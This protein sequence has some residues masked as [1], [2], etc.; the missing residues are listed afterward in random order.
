MNNLILTRFKRSARLLTLLCLLTSLNAFGNAIPIFDFESVVKGTT[1]F[2]LSSQ[3][4]TLTG[5]MTNEVS[6]ALGAPAAGTASPDSNGYMD[7]GYGTSG[8]S[9]GLGNVG[10]IKAPAGYTF[11]ATSF[12]V[13][14]S[15]DGGNNVYGGTDGTLGT[16]GLKYTVIGMKNNVMVVSNNVTDTARTPP[17]TGAPAVTLGGY[18]HH[19]AYYIDIYTLQGRLEV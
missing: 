11:R 10:G 17:E 13:W 2:S 7:T 1:S 14:P 15:S 19:I 16:V 12:D 5:D 6:S 3:T 9:H 4:W 18:W 8:I